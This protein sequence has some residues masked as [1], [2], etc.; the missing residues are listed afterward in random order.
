M[1][2]SNNGQETLAGGWGGEKD[3]Y[4]QDLEIARH[5]WGHTAKLQGERDSPSLGFCFLGSGGWGPGVLQHLRGVGDEENRGAQMVSFRNQPRFLK[6]R[7]L[8]QEEA[9]CFI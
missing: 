1:F 9:W 5:T 3:D 6:R 7:S 4:F 8:G 2:F